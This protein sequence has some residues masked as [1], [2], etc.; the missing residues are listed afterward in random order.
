MNKPSLL[1]LLLLLLLLLLLFVAKK[2][3]QNFDKN[4]LAE[5]N[6]EQKIYT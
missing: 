2:G 5:A 3:L 4:L 6:Y 1:F